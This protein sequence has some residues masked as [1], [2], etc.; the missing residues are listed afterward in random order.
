METELESMFN[1][2]IVSSQ[3]RLLIMRTW[4]TQAKNCSQ[5]HYFPNTANALGNDIPENLA[6]FGGD[7]VDTFINL[8]AIIGMLYVLLVDT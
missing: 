8:D 2:Q 6:V 3:S 1:S 5:A 4:L 7:S